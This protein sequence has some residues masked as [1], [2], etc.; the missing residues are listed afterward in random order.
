MFIIVYEQYFDTIS[1]LFGHEQGNRI[2]IRFN[3]FV[4]HI[5]NKMT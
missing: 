4:I 3:L 5:Q 2:S 1:K